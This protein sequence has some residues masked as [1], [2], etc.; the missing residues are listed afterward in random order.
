MRKI[1]TNKI[2]EDE[3]HPQ[4]TLQ[5]PWHTLNIEESL[6]SLKLNNNTIKVGLTTDEAAS[7]LETYGPNTMTEQRKKS[8][9]ER[10]WHQINNVLVYVLLFVAIVS[11][12]QAV[13]P[14]FN[15]RGNTK[16]TAWFQVALIIGVITLNTWIGIYQ[17]GNAEKAAEALK[18]MLSTD[19]RVLRG[20][21]V[22]MIPA[23]EIVPGDICHLHVGDKVPAD[24]RLISISN[25]A[26]AEAALTG[27]S[28]P[29]DK[30][31]DS[32]MLQDG[33][34]PEQVPLGDRKNMA[35]SATLVAQGSGCGIAI[36]TGDY[37]QIGTINRLVNNTE[38]IKTDVLRQI[39][40]ISK[41]LFVAIC[42]MCLAT[43]FVAFFYSDNYYYDALSSINIALTCAV[44]MVPEG[45]EAIVTISLFLGCKAHNAIVRALPSVETL[46]SVTVICSD[47]TGTLTQNVM[48]LTAFVTSNAHYKNDVD[49]TKRE[50][51][52]MVRD[53]LFLA[54]RAP[55]SLQKSGSQILLNGQSAGR[56]GHE[57]SFKFKIESLHVLPSQPAAIFPKHDDAIPVKNGES[58]TKEW[59]E[60]ALSCGILCSKCVLGEN[61]GR[62]GEIGN[63]TELSILRA[64]YFAGVDID[65]L[66]ADNP[67]I[68]EVPFSSEYKFMATIVDPSPDDSEG[69]Y[70]CYVKGAPDKMVKLCKNQAKGGV[71]GEENV[72]E[73]DSNY[74]SEQIAILSSHGLRVLGLC[75]A[76]VDKE[77]VKAGKQLGQDFV[78]GRPE[79]KWLTMVGL[80]AIMDPPR[81]ECVDAIV[82]AHDAGVRVAMITGDHKDTA[83][84]I[85]R[86][87]GIV[88][89]KFSEAVTGPELD[90]MSDDELRNSVMNH[91]VFARA[92]PQNKIRIV[93]AL[94]AEGQVTSMT[95]DGVN[96]A[97]A[98]KSANMGVAMGKEGTDVA[99][100]ASNMILADDNFATI[101]FAIKQ[102]RVVWDNLRKVMLVNTPI[103][104]SQ[105]LSVL[106]GLL[107][108]LPNTPIT[109]IQI[110]YSNF[111]CA[112]TLGF[113]CAI[114]PAE[115]GI[116]K[117]PPRRV[118]KRLIGRF[119]FLRII[120]ATCVLTGC[121]VVSSLI[122]DNSPHYDYLNVCTG[123]YEGYGQV[124]KY[125]YDEAGS[126][127]Y[128]ND[129]LMMIRAVAFNTLDF[130]AISV[131]MSARFTYLS[132]IH[133]RVLIG[134]PSALA[135]CGIVVLLQI[136]LTYTPG[137]NSFVFSM[138][139]MDGIG[140]AITLGFMFVVFVC[141]EMEKAV[142][143]S[144][145]SKGADTDDIFDPFIFDNAEG[146]GAIEV[147]MTMPKGVS[148]LNLTELPH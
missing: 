122:V 6:K 95:G 96:D 142:R 14:H 60:S 71:I 58:L 67:V 91:N 105:G 77:S 146:V 118:G 128:S 48:S 89:E 92:S 56:R 82:E 12:V 94:Q 23:G 70:I 103:N 100:E 39:D 148:K 75:R 19:A 25:L 18:N 46:G 69:N 102:G 137:L 15:T 116:M 101:V 145:K 80:C 129:R 10:I 66:K 55:Q 134:N 59:I 24:L 109:T 106:F 144:L 121:V 73:F 147:N 52:N 111:I 127:H 32:I 143:R 107:V 120:M 113:V 130:G 8:I 104:N 117:L 99:R 47:K 28:V 27:E 34:N 136:L 49:A 22:V 119:L 87:L 68:A 7:R 126:R 43:F 1:K 51:V 50:H 20:G 36:A 81:P 40:Q 131:M 85:G 33:T 125:C 93:K 26:T 141:M 98:L 16:F 11:L 4:A 65:E 114:E 45:L 35:Y 3:S 2:T 132:S 61:G 86:M 63:P 97:P 30:T 90:A 140:W 53:D 84:A 29:I 123:T 42:I 5:L 112:V 62:A 124:G 44:A 108:R 37:T 64:A 74:W 135:S 133:P 72:E 31:S 78:N 21:K 41:F 139:G 115:D 38:S 54:E 83:T 76:I 79:G 9:W 110:L 17:E 138:Q 57:S 13:S 88:N